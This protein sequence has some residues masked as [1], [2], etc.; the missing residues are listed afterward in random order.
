M[1]N[2]EVNDMIELPLKTSPVLTGDMSLNLI[3]SKNSVRFSK[4]EILNLSPKN[5]NEI[6]FFYVMEAEKIKDAVVVF[7]KNNGIAFKD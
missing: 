3:P 7:L 1:K 2:G 6:C 5:I 4:G